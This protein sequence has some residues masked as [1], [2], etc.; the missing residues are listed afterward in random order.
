MF[1]YNTQQD[2]R[3]EERDQAQDRDDRRNAALC[4]ENR[5]M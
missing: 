5:E 3:Q 4:V 2:W 1:S